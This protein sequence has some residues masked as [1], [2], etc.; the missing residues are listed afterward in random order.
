MS[1]APTDWWDL[2]T[3]IIIDVPDNTRRI[4]V[5]VPHPYE[6]NEVMVDFDA[7]G[8][9]VPAAHPLFPPSVEVNVG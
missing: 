1:D 3:Q 5:R 6:A 2:G 7:G 8:V 9:W 4:L